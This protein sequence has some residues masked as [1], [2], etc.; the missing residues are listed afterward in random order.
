MGSGHQLHIFQ[1]F[2]TWRCTHIPDFHTYTELPETMADV[3]LSL[4]GG[5]E[6][7]YFWVQVY[8]ITALHET[9]NCQRGCSKCTLNTFP[10]ELS[11]ILSLGLVQSPMT[12]YFCHSAGNM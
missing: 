7:R 9:L 6:N 5:A 1:N 3:L 8:L 10:G 12:F 11:P 2:P 4:E